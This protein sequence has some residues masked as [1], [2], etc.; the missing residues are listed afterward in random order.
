MA[1]PPAQCWQRFQ[2]GRSP[3]LAERWRPGAHAGLAGGRV[4]QPR[5]STPGNLPSRNSFPP[6]EKSVCSAC[7]SKKGKSSKYSETGVDT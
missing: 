7:D 1:F 6:K 3:A 5:G 2:R 4:L